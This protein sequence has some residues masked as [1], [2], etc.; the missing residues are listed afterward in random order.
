MT[1]DPRQTNG[2]TRASKPGLAHKREKSGRENMENFSVQILQDKPKTTEEK[3][4]EKW[5][6]NDD[7]CAV[8]HEIAFCF[9][10]FTQN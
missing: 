10:L 5:E 4:K 1:D 9:N 8:W 7:D 2:D 3:R 6:E